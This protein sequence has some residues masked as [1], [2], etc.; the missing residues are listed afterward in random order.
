MNL[1]MTYLNNVLS[2][3][4]MFDKYKPDIKLVSGILAL[5]VYLY[6]S[7]HCFDNV[8]SSFH[9]PEQGMSVNMN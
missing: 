9:G 8:L 6:T 7:D 4:S 3:L 1:Y 5:V 2:F